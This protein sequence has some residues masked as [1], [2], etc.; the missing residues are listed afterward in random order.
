M[1][2]KIKNFIKKFTNSENIIII[3]IAIAVSALCFYIKLNIGDELW[4]FS[5]IYKM[6]NGYEIYKDL[7]VI[8]TP[9][10]FYI[11][12]ILFTILGANYL[13]FRIYNLI[14]YTILYFLVYKILRKLNIK[15]KSSIIYL[16]IIY[17]ITSAFITIGGNYN[18]LAIVFVLIGILSILNKNK[19]VFQG[20]IIFLI[21]MSKQTIGIYYCI[22]IIIYNLISEEKVRN[23][24]IN[25]LK[26]V[27]TFLILF[28][29][30]CLYLAINNNLYNFINYTF[31]GLLDFERNLSYDNIFILFA[32]E[33]VIFIFIIITLILNKNKVTILNRN[34]LLILSIM[35][36]Q[37]SLIA[38]PIFN[39]AHILI[40]N[41][42]PLILFSYIFNIF[43]EKRL[44][45]MNKLKKAIDIL[46]NIIIS[47]TAIIVT[48]ASIYMNYL[49]INSLKNEFK[50]YYGAIIENK[51]QIQEVLNYIKDQENKEIEVKILSCEAN[52]YNNILNKNN[53]NI[54]LP[55]YGNLGYNGIENLINEIKT[56]KNVNILISKGGIQ[57]QEVKEII[58]FVK[59]NYQKIGEVGNYYIFKINY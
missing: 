50:P 5:N 39:N 57:Y 52:L 44:M 12:K 4:N 34:N 30:F 3:F 9:L 27:F 28:L 24:I 42:V 37:M 55:F 48:V 8:V 36:L 43:I 25:N 40:S 51:T 14:I 2:N 56:M 49:Y 18:I 41:Y 38:Y 35:S 23:K 13:V 7:N 17:A 46:A 54:D 15:R 16:I 20:F 6:T 21:F 33:I 26:T 53:K 1:K 31:L 22:G 19:P 29:C 58:D 47:I 32:V 59:E 45:K 11:G 10:F